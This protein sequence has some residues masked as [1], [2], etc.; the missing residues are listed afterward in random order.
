MMSK[1]DNIDQPKWE[2]V[3]RSLAQGNEVSEDRFKELT[4]EERAYISE[5]NN[6][7]KLKE[8]VAD[9]EAIDLSAD[10]HAMGGRLEEESGSKRLVPLL[11]KWVRYAAAVLLPLAVAL[12]IYTYLPDHKKQAPTVES[13]PNMPSKDVTLI[14]GDGS[15]VALKQRQSIKN[16][17]GTQIHTDAENALVYQANEHNAGTAVFNTLI[18]PRGKTYKLILDDL[19]E[20]WLNAD[21]RIRYRANFAGTAT[22]DVYLEKGEAYFQVAPNTGKPF[23]VHSGQM[24]VQVLGTAF[25]MH[26]YS[27]SILTTLVEGKV[28]IASSS[29]GK[30]LILSPGQQ[31]GFDKNTGSLTKQDVDVF[32]SVAWKDGMIVFAN[33]TMGDLM[34]Q[35]ARIYDY[36]IEFKDQ[37]LKQLH[38]TGR[39][40]RAES[41][42]NI[43]GI[44]EETSALKF[45]I[46][47]RT[48]IVDKP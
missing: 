21:S 28:K 44:I 7:Q 8:A 10:W 14:L 30:Q 23:I 43:L 22:R 32:P 31:S 29:S 4:A 45:T 47:D 1:P 24:N 26:T 9:L 16:P 25:N 48:V 11:S 35:L 33:Q 5:I 40:D 18:I 2:Q 12:G 3:L 27:G 34:E 20:I 39:A 19:T 42:Q 17:D 41:L 37:G 6:Q 13:Q 38:Y 36:E 46:K 15:K